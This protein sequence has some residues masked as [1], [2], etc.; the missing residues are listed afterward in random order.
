MRTGFANF[1]ETESANALFPLW[2][3]RDQFVV[4]DQQ[5]ALEVDSLVS[6]RTLVSVAETPNEIST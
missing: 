6:S 4:E 2:N 5:R 3:M 1:F